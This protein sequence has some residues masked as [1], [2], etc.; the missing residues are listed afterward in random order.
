MKPFSVKILI[1]ALMSISGSSLWAQKRTCD[2]EA[3]CISPAD[4]VINGSSLPLRYGRKNLGPDVMMKNDTTF[5]Q[6]YKILDGERELVYA[7]SFG[8]FG[9][10]NDTVNIGDSTI[11][12]A[13]NSF[14]SFNYGERSEPFVVDFCIQLDS[15]KRNAWGDTLGFNYYDSITENNTCCKPVVVMP[16][17]AASLPAGMQL[18]DGM[19]LYPN[20]VRDQLRIKVSRS[21]GQEMLSVV[22]RDLRGVI[23][24]EEYY[25]LYGI[26]EDQV[27]LGVQD[28]P[29]GLYTLSVQS[30][31]LISTK[32]FSVCK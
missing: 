9:G 23:C 20:P 6:L 14:I 7:G 18:P 3:I 10:K 13:N 5:V 1:L 21:C 11:Y 22:V 26:M 31:K 30:D 16:R 19:L 8:E 2:L 28:L 12:R 25:S 32:K 27:T 29:N 4:T 24:L 15:W 17:P